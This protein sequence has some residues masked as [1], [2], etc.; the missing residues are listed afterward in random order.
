M[1]LTGKLVTLL[2]TTT[3]S[4]PV[5]AF[6][7]FTDSNVEVTLHAL[8]TALNTSNLNTLKTIYTDNAEVIPAESSSLDNKS[9]PATFLYEQLKTGRGRYR[10]DVIDLHVEDNVAY[11]SALWSATV[12]TDANDATV[13]DGYIS[14]VLE[15]QSDGSW[16]IREQRWD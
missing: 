3:I 10:I 8:E 4:L 15:R 13:L 7:D 9:D 1:N 2:V 5:A 6:N 14:N 16:K 12:I 11:L